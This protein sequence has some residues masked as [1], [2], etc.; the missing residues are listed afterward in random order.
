MSTLTIEKIEPG[1]YFSVKSLSL[2][3]VAFKAKEG[4][5]PDHT[6]L[7]DGVFLDPTFGVGTV[8]RTLDRVQAVTI[9]KN[10]RDGVYVVLT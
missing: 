9:T 4:D 8:V 7:W 5:E 2:G 6:R 3:E 10:N 1:H